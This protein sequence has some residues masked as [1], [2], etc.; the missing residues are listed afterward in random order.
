MNHR[1][2]VFGIYIPADS[3]LHRMPAGAKILTI[4]ALSLVAL[5][6]N[7]W[8]ITL[9]FFF[10]CVI[11]LISTRAPLVT[12]FWPGW[13]FLVMAL[14]LVIYHLFLGSWQ[15]AI[16]VPVTMIACLYAARVLTYSTRGPDLVDALVAAGRPLR[17][18]GLSRLGL[19]PERF[20]LAVGLMLRS[21]PFIVGAFDDVRDAARARGLQRN[22]VANIS[23]VV[24]RT[25]GYAIATGDA[26][27]A[28]GLGE[29]DLD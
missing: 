26:L 11:A 24:V 1:D 16:V 23:P 15:Q 13:A 8:W 18:L 5:T 4:I 27:A 9:T 28:R 14:S 10:L 25:V 6:L 3:V 21:V 22:L 20:G 29:D 12:A 19:T 7:Q 2:A 17:W